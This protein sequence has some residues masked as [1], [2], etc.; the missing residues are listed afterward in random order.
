MTPHVIFSKPDA[1]DHDAEVFALCSHCG[2]DVES[3]ECER[4]DAEGVMGHD[5]GEDT[6]CCADPEDNVTCDMCDGAGQ[7][8]RCPKCG[9][10]NPPAEVTP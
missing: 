9:Y 6:C 8:W 7:N 3:E 1:G 2:S 5:C 4:C 10:I